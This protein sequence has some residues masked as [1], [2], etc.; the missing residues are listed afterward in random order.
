MIRMAL[1]LTAVSVLCGCTFTEEPPLR[2]VQ[3]QPAV[4][5]QPA[6]PA[7]SIDALVASLASTGGMWLNGISPVLEL[8]EEAPI[9]DLVA[10]FFQKVSYDSGPIG[11][12]KIVE[13]RPVTIPPGWNDDG[14]TAVL[15]DTA[16]GRKIL[17]L[18]HSK[19]GGWWC[20]V[21]DV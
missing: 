4:A 14:Y 19:A 12:T 17:V 3:L 2:R 6:A 15:I 16:D 8:P 10:E 7:D 5:E 20:R 11:S 13:I 9:E 1:L 21:Y 18:Q